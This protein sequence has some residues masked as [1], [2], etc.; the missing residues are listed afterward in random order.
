MIPLVCA[1]V[2][3]NAVPLTVLVSAMPVDVPP[4]IEAVPGVA[5]ATGLGFTVTSTV[6][7]VPSQ[8]FAFG[9]TV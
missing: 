2:H 9:V 8:P 6:N 1:T 4:Q 3:V 7:G 5:V